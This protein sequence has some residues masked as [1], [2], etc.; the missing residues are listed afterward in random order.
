MVMVEL[1]WCTGKA[2]QSSI[3]MFVIW[4]YSNAE[5][6]RS[7]TVALAYVMESERVSLEL[8]YDRLKH[9][10]PAIQPNPDFMSQLTNLLCDFMSDHSLC[11]CDLLFKDD[12]LTNTVLWS[13]SVS[14]SYHL[15]LWTAQS[16]IV[17]HIIMLWIPMA[18]NSSQLCF[19]VLLNVFPLVLSLS[20]TEG[21][22]VG[23]TLS[24]D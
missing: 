22:L 20:L 8:A 7:S 3:T 9:S 11:S 23:V 14:L 18:L 21:W 6:S 2:H 13:L 5:I 17:P 4:Y 15:I 16:L 10:R 1:Y 19:P 12:V 24:L